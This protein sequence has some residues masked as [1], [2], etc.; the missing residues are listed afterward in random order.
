MSQKLR[1]VLRMPSDV[2]YFL[3]CCLEVF[4]S[5]DFFKFGVFGKSRYPVSIGSN[6]NYAIWSYG[7]RDIMS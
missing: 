6:L 5:T 1:G 2:F 3:G 4:G 7:C